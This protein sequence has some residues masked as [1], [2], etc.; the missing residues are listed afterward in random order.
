M[1][2]AR[3][4]NPGH[5]L[6][7]RAGVDASR[8]PRI[9]ALGGD[10]IGP[11]VVSA[12]VRCLEALAL[13]LE[14]VRPLHGK[15]AV[16]ERGTPYPDET[17]AAV[18]SADAVL[19]GAVDTG[20]EGHCR[21]ILRHLRFGLDTHANLR[22]AVSLPGLPA[23]TGQGRTNLVIVRE[24]TEDMYPGCE[25]DLQELA[26]RWP[27]LK[28]RVGRPLPTAGKF[29]LRVI[30]ERASR[31]IGRYA[32][33]LAMRRRE[34]GVSSGHVTIVGKGNV[35]R[36]T[37]GLFA[38]A[39]E[40][41]LS[42][43]GGLTWD[44]LYVDEAARRLVANPFSFD[45]IVTSNLF[46]DILSDVASEV[47]GGMPAAPSA[48]IGERVAYFEPCHGSAPD[49]AGR[50]IANPSGAILSAAMMLAYL[51]L[52]D[53]AERLTAATIDAIIGGCRT[54]DRGGTA[55][56]DEMTAAVCAQLR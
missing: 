37:D 55:T 25:G 31:R 44:T 14:I 53:A 8:A 22:P 32:A 3:S 10:G 52:S 49:I 23:I 2:E 51:G 4:T 16:Q 41:E 12:A 42:E 40:A 28:D 17:R 27:G 21:P 35:L 19:F 36:D 9:V 46:G 26:A 39:C 11:E 45:V 33:R 56:S 6:I 5:W 1:G 48:S 54:R 7:P 38:R 15:D 50:G 34:L 20:P 13:P 29:A 18:E 24:L 30:T 47:M 43:H